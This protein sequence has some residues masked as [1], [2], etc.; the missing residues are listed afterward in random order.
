MLKKFLFAIILFALA[1]V[2]AAAQTTQNSDTVMVLPFEN[3]SSKPE[4]NWVGESFADALSDLLKAPGLNVVTNQERKI[5]QQRLR[6]PLT[7]LPS[8]ATSLKLAREGKASLLIAGKYSIA[9]AQGDTA[10]V[11]TVTTKIIRVNEGRF[12]SEEYDGKRITRDVNVSDALGNLQTIQGQIAYV[13]LYQLF[14]SALATPQNQLIEAANKVPARAFEAYIKGLLTPEADT[15]SRENFL[16][17]AMR[18]YAEDDKTK[19]GTYADA[20]LELGHFYL[21]Q[22]KF[23]EA[24]DYFSRVPQESAQYAEAAFYTGLIHWQQENYEQALA[25]LRPLADDLKLTSV[26]N[27][28]GAI[29]VQA[30][31]AEKKNKGKSDALMQEGIDYLKKAADSSADESAARFNYGFALFLNN[32]YTEAAKQLRPV[33]ANNSR[34]G[35]AYF[36]LAK[37]LEKTS[38][39]SAADFDNQARRFLSDNNRYARLATDWQTGKLDGINLRVEQPARK[40]FVSVVLIKKQATP[41]QTPLSETDALLA[42]AQALYKSGNDDEAMTVLRKIL[43]S[44]PMSAQAYLLLGMIHLRRGDL[45]QSVSSLK[46]ALFW[47]NRLLDAHIALG[48]IYI[49]KGDCSQAKTYAASAA[50]VDAENQEVA[51]LQRQVERCSTK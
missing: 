1:A 34:D 8:L 49:Q 35:E 37:A 40:D 25:V 11:V 45:E 13:I 10:A 22:K 28:L 31:R 48:K 6:V 51:A 38:D 7:I 42:Q 29:A 43:V 12:L 3:T 20:A 21:N 18:I 32:N 4:F 30:S 19:G 14:K 9:P 36:L 50:A 44:E 26:Y 24:V 47:D 16:K 2:S 39:A 5:I 15:Q 41:T 46:T 17:N 23:P 27:T 33:L